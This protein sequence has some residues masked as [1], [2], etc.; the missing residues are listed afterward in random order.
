MISK[1]RLEELIEQG[2]QVWKIYKDTCQGVYQVPAGLF[3]IGFS[4]QVDETTPFNE[5]FETIEEAEWYKEFGDIERTE[6]LKLPTWEEFETFF[7]F[8][9]KDGCDIVLVQAYGKLTL[10]KY[11]KDNIPTYQYFSEK[12]TKENY[13]L[14]C[15]KCKELFLGQSN[16]S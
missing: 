9:D 10:T 8:K 1:E 15:R 13:I 6:R 16:N 3:G 11:N 5:L 14:A 12:A 2:T 7:E 4:S